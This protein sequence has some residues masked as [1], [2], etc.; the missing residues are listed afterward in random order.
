[1]LS[2]IIETH[3]DEDGLARTL[4]SLV[5]AAVEGA[6]RDVIVCDRGSTDQSHFVADHAGCHYI[7]KGGIAAGIRHAKGEWL[8]LLEPGARL[9]QGWTEAVANH[10]SHSTS[11]ARFTRS[12]N[13][14]GDLFRRVFV[15]R[16]RP[17]ADGLLITRRQAAALS[18]KLHDSNALARGLSAKRLKA[19]ILVPPR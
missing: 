2:V 12:T 13:G 10:T 16:K 15:N 4:A 18:Q 6:V 14:H 5:Q 3:N 1:M 11:A 17:L 8:V 9:S 19:G 7:A